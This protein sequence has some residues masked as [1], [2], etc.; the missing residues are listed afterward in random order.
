LWPARRDASDLLPLEQKAY[1]MRPGPIKTRLAKASVCMTEPRRDTPGA[2][3]GP[4]AGDPGRAAAV[5]SRAAAVVA[6]EL[7]QVPAA[8]LYL[9]AT[10]IGHLADMTLRGLASLAAADAIYCEDTRHS[11]TLLAHYAISTPLESYHEHNAA[12]ERPRILA[13]LAAGQRV[14]LIADAGTPLVSDP[15]FKLVRAAIAAGHRV[16]ALPGASAL[17]AGLSVS[18]LATDTFLFAGFLPARSGQRRRRLAELGAIAA[19]LVLFEAPQRLAECLADIADV[20][21]ARDVA[22]ARELTKRHE[23]VRRGPA[24]ELAR[25][26]AA[27]PPRGEIVLLVGPPPDPVRVDAATLDAALAGAL[28][29]LS[30]RDA[31]DAVAAALGAPRRRVYERALELKRSQREVRS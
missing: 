19:T 22:I 24:P 8:G 30:V 1:N 10:P 27:V 5:A 26:V 15:G 31:V 18:G 21:G 9:V 12:Q 28:A 3:P 23:E 11:R 25:A 29:T 13:R 20:L 2:V 14:A 7:A 17:L 16:V 6:A 4:A